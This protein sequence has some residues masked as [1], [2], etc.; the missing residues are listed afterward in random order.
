METD[1]D[2]P[3]LE[4]DEP[5]SLRRHLPTNSDNDIP[6][7]GLKLTVSYLSFWLVQSAASGILVGW[8]QK[9]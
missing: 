4:S 2:E 1:V 3:V 7:M 6:L 9:S 5:I 8:I